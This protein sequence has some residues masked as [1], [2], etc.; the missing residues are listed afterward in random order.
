[1]RYLKR[2]FILIILSANLSGQS[3]TDYRQVTG[4][5][6]CRQNHREVVVIRKFLKGIQTYFFVVDPY[7]LNSSILR[8]DSVK[9]IS[10][11]WEKVY[12]RYNS[13]PYIRALQQAKK[14]SD[15]LQDAGFRRFLP[16]QRGVDL[17]VDLCPSSRPLD[18]IVFTDM[19]NELGR[20]EKP[21][22]VA[23]SVTG[24]WINSHPG[25][26]AWLKQLVRNG[27]LSIVW[28][29]HTYNHFTSKNIPLNRNFLLEPGTDLNQEILRT[30]IDMLQ[31]SVLPSVF[32][33][34][35]GLVS[36]KDI[37]DKILNFG[38]IP[39]GSDAWLAKGQ[40]P[41]PG[42]IVLI[43]A[44]GNEPLGVHD[45]INLLKNEQAQVLSG[46][47]EF[48]DLRESIIEDEGR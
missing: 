42:S 37:Y 1:M 24:R 33:R 30:E 23:V 29:N 26:L 32:F 2:I 35:P 31:N 48:Y 27:E 13:T 11:A 6:I 41:G 39:V 8:S 36:D 38:L 34:F 20:V 7:S 21:V 40:S 12:S 10:A 25:D 4:F 43:H 46:R 14:Y 19:I 17:T 16:E 5:G 44:N 3:I 18:R 45:F 28:I 22:P 47:W 15:T 9:Y